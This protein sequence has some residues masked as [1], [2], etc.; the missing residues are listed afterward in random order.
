MLVIKNSSVYLVAITLLLAGCKLP[1]NLSTDSPVYVTPEPPQKPHDELFPQRKAWLKSV[2]Y[3]TQMTPPDKIGQ[4]IPLTASPGCTLVNFI[5]ML[6]NKPNANGHVAVAIDHQFF[7]FGIAHPGKKPEWIPVSGGYDW[8]NPNIKYYAAMPENWQSQ[9]G[10]TV[11]FPYFIQRYLS[12]FNPSRTVFS[13]PVEIPQDQGKM[14][15]EWWRDPSFAKEEKSFSI[16][17]RHCTS[18]AINSYQE[19]TNTCLFKFPWFI[20][21]S[22]FAYYVLGDE[23]NGGPKSGLHHS[24]GLRNGQPVKAAFLKIGQDLIGEGYQEI[25]QMIVK[26][27]LKS[28][29]KKS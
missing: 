21:P 14:M 25:S 19:I 20:S 26:E 28:K 18:S 22:N 23:A 2:A 9:N 8:S 24:C 11:T 6:P 7:D 17:G 3:D 27:Y 13:I 16:P 15:K 5:V 12:L 1:V 29:C 10:H 4:V